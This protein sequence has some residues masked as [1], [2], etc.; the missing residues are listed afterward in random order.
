[1][2][3]ASETV[4]RAMDRDIRR[5]STALTR[6]PHPDPAQ[7]AAIAKHLTWMLE[8]V[9]RQRG[10]AAS[11]AASVVAAAKRYSGDGD[12]RDGL[13]GSLRELSTALESATVLTAEHSAI[14]PHWL[15][16]DAPAKARA[17]LTE[18][19]RGGREYRSRAY[20]CW[21]LPRHSSLRRQLSADVGVDVAAPP[22]AVWQVVADPV[23][24]CEWS[25]ECTEVEYLDGATESGLDVRFR[26][27]NR[28]GRTTWSRVCDGRRPVALAPRPGRRPACGHAPG[29]RAG[30]AAPPQ[31]ILGVASRSWRNSRTGC[32]PISPRR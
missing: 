18:R 3:E 10:S 25:H 6:W 20:R 28:S 19:L 14:T 30:R 16:D 5:A 9:D 21:Y 23:R 31:A 1:M 7:R 27:A 8:P 29:R 11:A 32:V 22:E 15:A 4:R 2:T 26:G 13:V 12:T 17:T 24:T